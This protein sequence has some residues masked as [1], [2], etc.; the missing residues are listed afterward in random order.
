M[1]VKMQSTGIFIRMLALLLLSA[2][3]LCLPRSLRQESSS[4]NITPLLMI[5]LLP[6]QA[7]ADF[8]GDSQLD[9][10]ELVSDGNQKNICL[11]F[12][13][14]REP[15]L[16]FSS[17]TRL[18]GSIYSQDID[19]DRDS[20]LI[21][22]SDDSPAHIMLWLNNGIGELARIEPG[23]DATEIKRRIGSGSGNSLIVSADCG[24][25]RAIVPHGFSLLALH[26]NQHSEA[27]HSGASKSFRYR[28]TS[29][30]SPSVSRYPKRGPP[31]ILS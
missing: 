9:R 7:F 27:L 15:S 12:S 21:W 16:N 26:E 25:L 1:T 20:D 3:S 28:S 22:I 29:L 23:A 24:W 13:S 30:L 8:D 2:S 5:S 19:R 6:A 17:E 10:A 31:S 11:T 18:A 4:L 14:R